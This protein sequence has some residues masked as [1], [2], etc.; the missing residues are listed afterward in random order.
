MSL[1]NRDF[2]FFFRSGMS[3]KLIDSARDKKI[4]APKTKIQALETENWIWILIPVPLPT[5]FVTMGK[6]LILQRACN[7]ATFFVRIKQ[8]NASEVFNTAPAHCKYSI[9]GSSS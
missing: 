6:S 3:S 2:N 5:C 9:S 4:T 1:Q 8:D 7:N